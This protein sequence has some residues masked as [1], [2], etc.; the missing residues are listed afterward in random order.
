MRKQLTKHFSY[1]EMTKTDTGL[2]NTPSEIQCVYLVQTCR[3]LE[4]VRERMNEGYIVCVPLRI[5]SGFRTK[6]VNSAVGGTPNSY[7]LDGRAVDIDT[8]DLS[9]EML[10][11]LINLLYDEY[12]TELSYKPEKNIVHVVF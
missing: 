2:P 10:E 7:H 4:R 6:Q 3:I 8:S 1:K 9:D 11:R 12:P 5:N